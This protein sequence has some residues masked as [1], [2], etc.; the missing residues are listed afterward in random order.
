MPDQS[1]DTR[2]DPGAAPANPAQ[3]RQWLVHVLGIDP[4]PPHHQSQGPLDYLCHTFFESARPTGPDCLVWACRGGGKTFYSAVATVLDMAFKPGI[5]IR[6]LG[7]SREQS[8]RM[9]EHLRR[10]FEAPALRAMVASRPTARAIRLVNGSRTE[11]LAQSPTSVRGVRVQK[12]R[13]DEVELFD[14][15]IWQAAQLVTRSRRCGTVPVHGAVE[16]LSTAHRP[17]GL[18]SRLIDEAA[19]PTSPTTGRRL[20]RWTVIDA[21]E[22]CDHRRHHCDHCPLADHCNARARRNAGHI[23]VADAVSLKARSDLASWESEM[24]CLRPRRSDA[25]F[26]EFDPAI[27]VADFDPP[28]IDAGGRWVC[29]MDFGFR[30]PAVVLWGIATDEASGAAL[31][32]IDEHAASGVV[33]DAH[34]QAIVAGRWPRPAWIGVDPA[35]AQRSEQTGASAITLLKRAGLSVRHPRIGFEEGLRLIRARLAPASGPVRLFIHRRCERLVQAMQTY[36]FPPHQPQSPK[37]VKDGSDHAVDA[38]RYLINCLERP[39]PIH[40]GRY[41]P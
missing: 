8:E 14:P 41:T 17:G 24:L 6:L 38:L 26:P 40:V 25:V 4:P 3:L 11:I 1:L 12:L 39:G 23:T 20:F 27:H 2:P 19:A 7:G 34:I 21:L 22:R 33:L 10:L 37:P 13:C 36:H 35:G 29:G 16:A 15:E 18:M 30:A 28:P 9:H 32:I 31:H 5:E